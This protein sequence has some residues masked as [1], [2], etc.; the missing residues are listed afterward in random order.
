MF[1]VI[2]QSVSIQ[3]VNAYVISECTQTL[4]SSAVVNV[5][6]ILKAN[7][8]LKGILRDAQLVWDLKCFNLSVSVCVLTV[9]LI[10]VDVAC[11][12][13][14]IVYTEGVC[15]LWTCVHTVHSSECPSTW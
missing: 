13:C 14:R 3:P 2:V 12:H 5:V 6:K 15:T 7:V 10:C 1:A 11:V 4:N 9:R 8:T